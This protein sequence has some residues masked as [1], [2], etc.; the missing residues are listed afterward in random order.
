[1]L[2]LR[3]RKQDTPQN[4]VRADQILA[5]TNCERCGVEG[6]ELRHQNTAYNEVLSN[7]HVLCDLCDEENEAYW[8]ERWED[9]YSGLL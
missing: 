2:A 6:A 7:Y 1:M 4:L 5:H 9:Y 8:K 3:Q